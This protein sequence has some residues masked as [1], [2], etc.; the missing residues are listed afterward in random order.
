MAPTGHSTK[1]IELAGLPSGDTITTTLH[2]YVGDPDGPTVYLE[3]ALHGDE[4]NGVE[5]IRRVTDGLDPADLTGQLVVVPVANP[6]AFDRGANRR[7][8]GVDTVNSGVNRIWPGDPD[9]SPYEQLTATL[10]EFA[11]E[12]DAIVDLHGMER[13]V[14]PYILASDHAPSLELAEVFGTELISHIKGDGLPQTMLTR[15]ANEQGIPSITPELGHAEELQED[16]AAVGATGVRN[17]LKHV[18]VMPGE[19]VDNG[20]PRRAFEDHVRATESGLFKRD[21]DVSIGDE[22]AAGEEL[23]VVYDPATLAVEQV[24]TAGADGLLFH[25]KGR[26]MVQEGNALGIVA[27]AE[28]SQIGGR[29]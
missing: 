11:R 19:P 24:V 9:G 13:Y 17:V 29:S 27:V 15:H 6:D 1:R 14:I 22:V 28:R 4:I 21:P 18:G 20:T 3:A 10:W 16:A 26:S 5:V 12:A 23:G 7:G 2:R 25:V 8:S